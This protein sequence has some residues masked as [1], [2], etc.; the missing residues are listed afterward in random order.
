MMT[1]EEYVALEGRQCPCCGEGHVDRGEIDNTNTGALQRVTCEDCGAVWFDIHNLVRFE[2]VRGTIRHRTAEDQPAEPT[3][4][5]IDNQQEHDFT[6][7]QCG[8]HNRIL[9]SGNHIVCITRI[10]PSPSALCPWSGPYP[11]PSPTDN[12]IQ[13]PPPNTHT[14]TCPDCGVHQFGSYERPDGSREYYCGNLSCGWRGDYEF[15]VDP[16]RSEGV[17]QVMQG[18]TPRTNVSNVSNPHTSGGLLGEVLSPDLYAV[19]SRHGFI[20]GERDAALGRRS[21]EVHTHELSEAAA[22]YVRTQND[23][24]VN[25]SVVIVPSHGPSRGNAPNAPK[26]PTVSWRGEDE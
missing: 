10:G 8:G 22:E 11:P 7:P 14:F 6:C 3:T 23:P 16:N 5:P 25:R 18:F 24:G 26:T 20:E 12:L 1:N 4:T 17:G 21:A 15:A 13:E 2:L 19:E 9:G